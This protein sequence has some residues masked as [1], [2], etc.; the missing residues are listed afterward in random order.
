MAGR[1]YNQISFPGENKEAFDNNP[2]I[3]NLLL[4]PFFKGKIEKAQNGWRNVV[5]AAAINGIPVPAISSALGY[6]D[7]Y[8]CEKLPANLLQAQRDYFGAHTYERTDTDQEVNFSIPTGQDEAELL[9]LQHIMFKY[10][11]NQ[12]ISCLKYKKI[13]N[14]RWTVCALI[15]FATTMN[16]L[17]RQVIGILKPMLESDLNIG[18]G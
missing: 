16:Y 9:L 14:Y 18:E 6:F 8:R 5:S 1:L 13:G 12:P 15:F 2:D 17:D 3:T 10:N 11:S 7:G 4:D